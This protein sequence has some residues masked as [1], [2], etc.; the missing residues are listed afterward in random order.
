MATWKNFTK[1][2]LLEYANMHGTRTVKLSALKNEFGERI[3]NFSSKSNTPFSKF[4]QTL[5]RLRDDDNFLY[6]I[7]NGGTYTL[8]DVALD[9]EFDDNV[10]T[11]E[12]IA[13][14]LNNI[15]KASQVREYYYEVFARDIKQKKR[16][17]EVYQ[18]RC[19]YQ[20]CENSFI[21][22]NGKNYIEVHHITPLCEY[23]E[24]VL[25]NLSTLCAHHHRMAHF[26]EPSIRFEMR[27]YLL[28]HTAE[29]L[30]DN[31]QL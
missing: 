4:E 12:Y 25:E 5:Q 19:L 16:A 26:A 6:F 11:N 3:K 10:D 7:D 17:K 29:I 9:N 24:D 22:E 15:S 18:N 8:R 1:V 30:K 20:N 21:M 23:G 13:K 14:S 27:N 31:I 28:K 2:L